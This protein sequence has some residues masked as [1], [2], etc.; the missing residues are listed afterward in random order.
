MGTWRRWVPWVVGVVGLVAV[1]AVAAQETQQ[2]PTFR[3]GARFVR[4]DVYPT[5]SEGKPI[6]GLTAADFELFEDGKPQAIDTFD[7]VRIE[8]EPE[9]ARLDPNSQKE[10]EELAKDPRARVFAIVLDTRHVD[11]ASG[12]AL[13]APLVEMLDRL[14]G[15]TDMF[16]VITPELPPSS[17]ILGRRTTSVADMLK[18]YWFWGADDALRPQ[19]QIEQLLDSCFGHR[20]SAGGGTT[21]ALVA[22]HRERQT[23]EHLSALVDKLHGIR[24]ERKSVILVTQG[25]PLFTADPSAVDRLKKKFKTAVPQVTQRGGRI[26]LGVPP[27][28]PED[29]DNTECFAQA[30][31]LFMMESQRAFND[32][33]EKAS[34][35][36]VAFYPIDPRGLAPFD[37]PI[38]MGVR[39]ATIDNTRIRGRADGLRALAHNTDGTAFIM[40]NDLDV[41]FKMLTDALSAYYLLGYYSTNTKFD[42]KYRRLEVKVKRPGVQL[43]ARRGYFAPSEEEMAAIAAGREAAARPPDEGEAELAGA[44][45]RLSELRHD[46]DLFL[47]T[48][49]TPRVLLL[50]VELGVNARTSRAWT[51]GGEVRVTIK[52]SE[53]D[54]T[55]TRQLEPLRS[56][57]SLRIAVE[58]DG[59]LKIEV[60]ARA[61]VTGPSSAADAGL[62]APGIE[63]SLIG[64]PLTWRGLARAR[65]PA[66]DGRYR[67]TERATLEA[68]LF[69]GAIPAGARVLD[70]SGKPLNV[71]IASRER[72][73]AAGTRWMVAEVSLAPLADGDY[74]IELDA[75][76][77]EKRERRLFA[78]R[79]VR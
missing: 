31:A 68:P 9:V 52:T 33:M 36:N 11:I 47:Q 3:G 50:N 63:A 18:R 42:G 46:R 58:D 25:W 7:F 38:S 65:Q 77:D 37:Q 66:A 22:R 78:I 70:I 14:I 53:G 13:R 71:P 49:R 48:A 12:R 2:R 20:M 29:L 23:L 79:V 57:V 40:N 72:I 51:D 21:Q 61:K 15:P 41:Q 28:G 26:Q 69:N 56:G 4:V 32:L 76:Q 45:A 10:G 17:F 55:E 24:D 54:L 6:E 74:V 43:K 75:M 67:R 27:Q 35:A 64:A 1:G 34:R 60:R 8:P 19:D 44:L 30:N 39:S 73:D 5:D 62:L 16:G 59:P